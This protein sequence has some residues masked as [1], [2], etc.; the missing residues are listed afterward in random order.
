[1][2]TGSLAVAHQAVPRI[3]DRALHL[4]PR[5]LDTMLPTV[6]LAAEIPLHIVPCFVGVP[7]R[8]FV[9]EAIGRAVVV[10]IAPRFDVWPRLEVLS[11]VRLFCFPFRPSSSIDHR[12][13]VPT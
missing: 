6:P 10:K 2:G 4:F 7:F 11:P 12:S 1:M 8:R 3:F 13:S 9:P 5:G